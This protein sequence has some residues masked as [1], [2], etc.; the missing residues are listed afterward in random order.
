MLTE[1]TNAGWRSERIVHL[2]ELMPAEHAA[3]PAEEL[4][5][6]FYSLLFLAQ[7]IRAVLADADVRIDV[8]SSGSHD[9]LGAELLR[10]ATAAALGIIKV[11]SQESPNIT[12]RSVDLDFEV[13]GPASDD[14]IECLHDELTKGGT[15]G[16]VAYRGRHRWKP[17]FEPI[18]VGPTTRQ[19]RD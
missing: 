19:R 16:V 1:L 9:V 3:S 11:I 4:E 14:L 17:W 18:R 15:D 12:C 10:P 2:R 6:G 8:V 13:G 7:A 5:R